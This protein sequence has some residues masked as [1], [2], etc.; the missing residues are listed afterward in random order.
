MAKDCGLWCQLAVD[1]WGK[2]GVTGIYLRNESC[3][4][5]ELVFVFTP[6]NSMIS[7]TPYAIVDGGAECTKS[8]GSSLRNDVTC[9]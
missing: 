7:N 8:K 3:I 1:P 9:V 4:G 2:S 5:I 6:C